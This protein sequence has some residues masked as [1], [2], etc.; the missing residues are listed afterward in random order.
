M[1]VKADTAGGYARAPPD[2]RS[3]GR[4]DRSAREGHADRP[5]GNRV[6]GAGSSGR[7]GSSGALVSTGASIGAS[8]V[9]EFVAARRVADSARAPDDSGP[10]Q[11][12]Q[13][14]RQ[15]ST[16]VSQRGQQPGGATAT[17]SSAIGPRSAPNTSHTIGLRSRRR[18]T[19]PVSGPKIVADMTSSS[20]SGPMSSVNSV[21]VLVD[22]AARA[23]RGRRKPPV[24]SAARLSRASSVAGSV[25]RCD[26]SD[27]RA[28]DHG[29][30]P[31]C[32]PNM[33]RSSTGIAQ[34]DPSRSAAD[35]FSAVSARFL[36]CQRWLRGATMRHQS[37]SSCP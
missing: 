21:P 22:H 1:P 11:T 34:I 32:M 24:R 4:S 23:P 20:P 6:G 33:V 18:A 16:G 3:I 13:R 12:R 15:P 26:G 14:A 35:C 31:P 5:T 25:P 19:H 30:A 10:P 28:D 37:I 29:L 2:R 8:I 17:I 9:A 36:Y 7:G 27:K